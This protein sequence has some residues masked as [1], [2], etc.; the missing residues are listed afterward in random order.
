MNSKTTIG[1]EYPPL[2]NYKRDSV[3]LVQA[4]YNRDQVVPLYRGNPLI[5]ALPAVPEMKAQIEQLGC[6]PPYNARKDPGQS[7]A[8]RS[9]MLDGL[10][11]FFQPLPRH[12]NLTQ[13][14]FS[15]IRAGYVGRC[16]SWGKPCITPVAPAM[17]SA[18][19]F[20]PSGTGKTISLRRVLRL[21]DQVILHTNHSEVLVSETQVSWLRVE[22]PHDASPRGL[23]SAI[24]DKLDEILGTSYAKEFGGERSTANRMIPGVASVARLHYLGLLVI[25]EIQNM[26]NRRTDASRE[27]ADFIVRIVNDFDVPVLMVG[28][29]ETGDFLAKSFRVT[30]RTTGLLQPHW[31]R[32]VENECEWTIFTDALWNYQYVRTNTELTSDLRHKLFD[33]TQGIPDLAVKLH[34]LTQRYAINERIEKITSDLL[35]KVNETSFVQNKRYLDD[36][37]NGRKPT[38]DFI[39]ENVLPQETSLP[40]RNQQVESASKR[41]KLFKA[42][43]TGVGAPASAQLAKLVELQVGARESTYEAAKKSGLIHS[44]EVAQ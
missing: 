26:L 40:S 13:G 27:L 7:P 12:F 1:S 10:R 18:A 44:P 39:C 35:E 28:T 11:F 22:C 8:D 30:R 41:K 31:V 29:S 21:I 9:G 34:I 20:G 43:Q 4:R 19:L 3:K 16:P 24:L 5:E 37:R 17:Q 36:L 14:I 6:L 32:M 2:I 42:V 25:D 15:M 33:L 38:E 23:C